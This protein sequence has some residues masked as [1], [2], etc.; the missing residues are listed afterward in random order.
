M[1]PLENLRMLSEIKNFESNLVVLT[2]EKQS[3][4]IKKEKKKK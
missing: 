3:F 1:A 4:F 2:S